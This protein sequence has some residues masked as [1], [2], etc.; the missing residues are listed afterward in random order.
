MGLV[1]LSSSDTTVPTRRYYRCHLR[2]NRTTPP[3]AIEPNEWLGKIVLE[4]F[5]V[6]D[7]DRIAW[8]FGSKG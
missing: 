8:G 3:R 2:D 4:I 7:V 1:L 6:Y 5:S